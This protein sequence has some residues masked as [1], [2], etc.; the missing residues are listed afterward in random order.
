MNIEFRYLYR[1]M[2]NFKN[3]GEVIFANRL[4]SDA[5]EI[6]KQIFSILG[7]DHTI[8]ASDLGIP[9]LFFKNFTYDPELDHEMHEFVEVLRTENP[10]NDAAQRDIAYLLIEMRA[11][12]ILW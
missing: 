8:K 12:Q 4:N 3:Y 9:D 1:D 5:E 6:R 10:A 11:H 7:P 2:G